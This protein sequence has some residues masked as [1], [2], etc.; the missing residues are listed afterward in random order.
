M[1]KVNA[2]SQCVLYGLVTPE[3][4]LQ[5]DEQIANSARHSIACNFECETLMN[6]SHCIAFTALAVF[7][8]TLSTLGF[9]N[10][11]VR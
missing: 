2:T 1:L 11:D 7:I 4:K 3:R 10:Q 5:F 6:L 9:V 8:L